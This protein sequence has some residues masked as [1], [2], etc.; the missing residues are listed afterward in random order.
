MRK[1]KL[2]QLKEVKK[3]IIKR[4]KKKHRQQTK[5]LRKLKRGKKKTQVEGKMGELERQG[6]K[7]FE[8]RSG[9]KISKKGMNEQMNNW[10]NKGYNMPFSNYLYKTPY[11]L[12][13]RGVFYV[14][15]DT[16]IVK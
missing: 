13:W 15:V 1:R 6:Y 9:M 12:F 3:Q 10:K 11:V 2:R 5:E 7:M 14:V 16:T 8:L 4:I